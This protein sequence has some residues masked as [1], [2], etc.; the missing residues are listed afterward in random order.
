MACAVGDR[1]SPSTKSV[2]FPARARLAAKCDADRC[3]AFPVSRTRDH[4]HARCVIRAT[5]ANSTVR[6]LSTDSDKMPCSAAA[7]GLGLRKSVQVRHRPKDFAVQFPALIS[8][9][10]LTRWGLILDS[11]D[12]SDSDCNTKNSSE[13]REYI[14]S[15]WVCSL[16]LRRRLQRNHARWL[17]ELHVHYV[18]ISQ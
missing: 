4:N 7:A 1:K 9:V 17:T 15:R 3:L 18:D 13:Q 2:R 12:R 14:P 11:D 10:V 8:L 16:R 6:I 5:V